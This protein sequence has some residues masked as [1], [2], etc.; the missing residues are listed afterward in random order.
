VDGL[1]LFTPG[2]VAEVDVS[3]F[4]KLGIFSGAF[5]T[6][7]ASFATPIE[8]QMFTTTPVWLDKIRADPLRL[9]C[10][11]ARFF[12]ESRDMD[13]YFAKNMERNRLPILVLLASD[14]VII[15]N[16]GV[17]DALEEGRQSILDVHTYEGQTHSIQFDATARLVDD[18]VAWIE[19]RMEAP[20]QPSP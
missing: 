2:I 3:L 19:A 9:H 17:V 16:D 8:P 6:P 7:T 15:D 14:D 12:W 18:T 5:I 13:K 4:A 11:T 10:A 1:I 20:V